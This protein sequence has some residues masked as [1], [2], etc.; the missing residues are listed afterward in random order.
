M[1][2][3]LRETAVDLIGKNDY[4][5][6]IIKYWRL[7]FLML[8]GKLISDEAY[9]KMQYKSRTGKKLH[10]EEPVLYNEKVQYAKLYCR[11]PRMKQLVDKYAVREYVKKTIGEQYLTKL[12]GVYDS[13][14]EIPFDSLPDQF[15]MKL[16]NGSGYNIICTHKT[17]KIIKKIKSRFQKWLKVDFY[18]LGR[19]WAYQNVPNRI[20]CEEYLQ[21]DDP[22]GLNDYKVFCFHGVPKLI[23]VDY[24]RFSGH[25]RNL[26]TPE[27]EFVDEK[28][29]YENDPNADIPKPENL[30][31]MLRCAHALS[32]D[33]PHVRV[34]FYAIGSRLVFGEMT[35][36]HGAGYLH[37]ENEA[38]ERELGSDWEIKHDL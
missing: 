33:F 28:V 2:K 5:F 19:E 8:T 24:A 6:F 31:E 14:E 23:Q 38:F 4:L 10:L 9:I 25:K 37:F 27:W 21:C 32:K 29:A 11:D 26:Y 22:Y 15:V 35:F 7:R 30:A 3:G 34:D 12:Y 13:V 1:K 18:M 36:Y 20:I 16:T 17:D